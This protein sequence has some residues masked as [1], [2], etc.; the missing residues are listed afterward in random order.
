M[1]IEY[2]LYLETS[3]PPL[4]LHESVCACIAGKPDDAH[5]GSLAF[6]GETLQGVV[7]VP[8]DTTR[9]FVSEDFSIN[10]RVQVIFRLDKFEL[11]RAQDS[12]V[13]CMSELL[14]ADGSDVTLLF[15]GE[16]VVLRRRAG[17]LV[18][19]EGFGV[20]TPARLS[21]LGTPYQLGAITSL[22]VVH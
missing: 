1:A 6:L 19:R 12:L 15:N 7:S 11:E 21:S 13:R 10:A 22:E 14:R 8:D 17:E 2:T 20:W 9:R 4:R 3:I 18:L 16:L 5:G